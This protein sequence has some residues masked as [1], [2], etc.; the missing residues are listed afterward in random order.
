MSQPRVCKPC[1]YGTRDDAAEHS[2]RN[3]PDSAKRSENAL[4]E[5]ASLRPMQHLSGERAAHLSD[6]PTSPCSQNADKA[7]GGQIDATPTPTIAPP[8]PEPVPVVPVLPLAVVEPVDAAALEGSGGI[9]AVICAYPWDCYTAIR[10]ARCE[11]TLNPFAVGAGSYGLMQIQ[12]SVHAWKWPT[13]WEDWMI[14]ERNLQYA[15]EIYQ[16]RG[17]YAWSCF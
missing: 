6:M 14:P 16:G 2:E 10:V 7:K 12:A 11:S 4:L 9:E 1:S 5:G 8:T 3:Q 15:W 17:W 13:F